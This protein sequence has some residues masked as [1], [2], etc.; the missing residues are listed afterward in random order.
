MKPSHWPQTDESPFE[1]DGVWYRLIILKSGA[2]ILK[3]LF[4]SAEMGL[5]ANEIQIS[6]LQSLMSLHACTKSFY[7]AFYFGF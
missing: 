3:G 5:L 2:G 1:C 4:L 6:T 7:R